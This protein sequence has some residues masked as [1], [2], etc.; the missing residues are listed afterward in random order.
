MSKI[1]VVETHYATRSEKQRKELM[2]RVRPMTIEEAK[3][4]RYG[5]H[6]LVLSTSGKWA[7]AKVNGEPKTWKTRPEWCDVS[8]KYGQYEYFTESYRDGKEETALV[9]EVK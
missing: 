4:L 3:K 9:V 6:V 2:K 8:L 7:N 1:R 5:D